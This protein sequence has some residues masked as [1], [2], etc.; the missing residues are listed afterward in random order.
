M[1]NMKV[2]RIERPKALVDMAKESIRDLIITGHLA[3]GEKISESKLAEQLG[4]STTPVREAFAFLEREGLVS[5]LPQRGTFVFKL[6]PGEL[7]Y[8]CE[9]R[10]ALEPAALQL[11]MERQREPFLAALGETVESMERAIGK[12]DIPT[13]LTLDTR[14]H[15]TFFDHSG[16]PYLERAYGLI[17]GKIAALRNRLGTDPHHTAKSLREHRSMLGH[18]AKGRTTDAIQVLLKHIARKEGSYWEY[19]DEN[20]STLLR[21]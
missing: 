2:Q 18:L 21:S 7:N 1:A 16:N 4:I 5:I 15:Q 6:Q 9:L 19:F 11:A 10:V 20:S 8:I 14:F 13:Y 12:S 17:S 3:M